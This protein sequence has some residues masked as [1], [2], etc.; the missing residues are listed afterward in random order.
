MTTLLFRISAAIGLVGIVMGIAM[1]IR[2]DFTLMPAHAHLNLVGFIMMFLSAL[3]Y[4]ST[5]SAA[6]TSLA[7]TQAITSIVG[8]VVF[9]AGIAAVLLGGHGYEPL[10]IIG[11]LIVLA[12]A[13]MFAVVVFRSTGR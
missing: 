1:G 6:A 11:S 8:A 13:S 5:P 10:A 4:R 9:P 7:K 3:Y 12:S 2:Q